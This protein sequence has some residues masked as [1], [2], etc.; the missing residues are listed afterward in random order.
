MKIKKPHHNHKILIKLFEVWV[1]S[2][3][4]HPLSY[5]LVLPFKKKINNNKLAGFYRLSSRLEVVR[6]LQSIIFSCHKNFYW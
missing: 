3:S 6:Y 4:H 5:R 1:L 2:I